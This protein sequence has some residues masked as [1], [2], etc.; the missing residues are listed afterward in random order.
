MLD[1][2]DGFF[3]DFKNKDNVMNYRLKF[4]NFLHFSN[5]EIDPPNIDCVNFYKPQNETW[6]CMFAQYLL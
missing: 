2:P 3:W 1:I 4:Q 6:K 5:K